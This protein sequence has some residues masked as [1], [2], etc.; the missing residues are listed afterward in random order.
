MIL[1]PDSGD[2]EDVLPPHSTPILF[3]S[4]PSI[5]YAIITMRNI[6]VMK[7]GIHE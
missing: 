6:V 1:G 4:N 3:D 2:L 7:R 5:R